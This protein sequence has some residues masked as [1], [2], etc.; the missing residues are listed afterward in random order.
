VIFAGDQKAGFVLFVGVG[1]RSKAPTVFVPEVSN[2]AKMCG[3]VP[4]S[5]DP[6]SPRLAGRW[7]NSKWQ[8][9][10]A[11]HVDIAESA[12]KAD[13]D[14]REFASIVFGGVVKNP[15]LRAFFDG[16]RDALPAGMGAVNP[17]AHL[18]PLSLRLRAEGVRGRFLFRQCTAGFAQWLLICQDLMLNLGHKFAGYAVIQAPRYGQPR[19]HAVHEQLYALLVQLVRDFAELRDFL[20]VSLSDYCGALFLKPSLDRLTLL[21]KV[22]VQGRKVK[23]VPAPE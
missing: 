8:V 17:T 15:P 16:G 21:W 12:A 5:L 20:S 13:V 7:S 14:S 2:P 22:F 23:P 18:D 4:E 3:R 11:I 6:L 10:F 1:I 9:R 19:E